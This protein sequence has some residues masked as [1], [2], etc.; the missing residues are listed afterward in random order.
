MAQN[1]KHNQESTRV[2]PGRGAR[3]ALRAGTALQALH[4]N[5]SGQPS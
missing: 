4:K 5:N 1:E 2:I 3:E